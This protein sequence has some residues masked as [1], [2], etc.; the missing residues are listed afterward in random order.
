VLASWM[1][2][3]AVAEGNATLSRAGI[4]TF[5]FP[6]SAARAFL[7]MWRYSYNLGSLYETPVE[8]SR[9]PEASERA[10]G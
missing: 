6:D 7:D 3:Q 9:N 2:G 1:G 10:S 4:P 8:I 5:A